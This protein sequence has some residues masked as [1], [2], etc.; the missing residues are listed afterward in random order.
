MLKK[1]RCRRNKEKLKKQEESLKRQIEVIWRF[2]A[3]CEHSIHR[4]SVLRIVSVICYP[5]V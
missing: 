1:E 3:V 5:V 2:A 4:I